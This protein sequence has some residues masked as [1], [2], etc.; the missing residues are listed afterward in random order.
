MRPCGLVSGVLTAGRA[1]PFGS[2]PAPPLE[3]L[4]TP[5]GGAR[6]GTQKAPAGFASQPGLL[7]CSLVPPS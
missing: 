4:V 6:K 1:H 2:L 7:V 3:R 5:V